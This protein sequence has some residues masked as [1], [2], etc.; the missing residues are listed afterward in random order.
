MIQNE[1]N[2]SQENIS[3]FN[4]QKEEIN[5]KQLSESHENSLSDYTESL[6]KERD[7]AGFWKTAVTLIYE[8]VRALFVGVEIYET[9]E[10]TED[11]LDRAEKKTCEVF[12]EWIDKMKEE[13]ETASSVP[14]V[15]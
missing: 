2:N 11:M 14:V 3:S 4:E 7:D 8:V 13:S 12:L 10:Y 6:I 1:N 5:Y 9:G 15:H